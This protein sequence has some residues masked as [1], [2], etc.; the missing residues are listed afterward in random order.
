MKTIHWS[1]SSAI[2]SNQWQF[3]AQNNLIRNIFV[4]K[5]FWKWS[6]SQSSWQW[7]DFGLIRGHFRPANIY[8]RQLWAHSGRTPCF[9]RASIWSVATLVWECLIRGLFLSLSLCI[10]VFFLWLSLF[11]FFLFFFSFVLSF[12]LSFFL[13]FFLSFGFFL[14][15]F[16]SFFSNK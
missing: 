9:K 13:S 7:S 16:C 3:R 2:E 15:S 11:L 8:R 1:I 10:A 5:M 12:V 6:G 14:S 4:H